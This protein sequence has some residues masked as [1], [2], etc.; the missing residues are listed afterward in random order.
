MGWSDRRTCARR[1]DGRWWRCWERRWSRR[2]SSSSTTCRRSEE[3]TSELQSRLHLVCR[4][5]LGKKKDYVVQ[6]MIPFPGTLANMAKAA[7]SNADI[8]SFFFNAWKPKTSPP[9]PS[10]HPELSL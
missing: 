3:H 10:P 6:Q 5:L 1:S 7:T 9:L 8:S 4:L 2:R